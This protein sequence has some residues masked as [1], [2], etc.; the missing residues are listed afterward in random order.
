[1]AITKVSRGL[2]ST[3]VSD[4]SD[5]TAITIDSSENV[6]IGT[7]SPARKVQIQD[8]S[9]SVYLAVTSANNNAA[10]IMFGDT[11]DETMGRVTYDNTNNSMQFWTNDSQKMLIDS[12]GN[13]GIGTSS[14]AGKLQA[15]T[16][17]NRFQSLQGAAADLEIVSDNN[18]SPVALIKGTGNADLLNVFD[19]TTE[20][21]TILDGGN[22]GIGTDSPSSTLDVRG[23]FHVG[24]SASTT[25]VIGRSLAPAGSQG[26]LLTSGLV[27]G[28][29]TTTPTFADNS[30][31]GASI[32]LAGNAADQYGGNVILKAYGA[33]GTATCNLITFENRSGTNTFA[34]RMRIDN[35]GT[36][37]VGATSG[38][39]WLAT[40]GKYVQLGDTYPLA[41]TNNSICSIL[42]RT[43][44]DGTILEFKKDASVVGSISTNA[45]SLPSDRN[46]KKDIEDLNIG[47][48]LVSKLNPVSYNYKIDNDGTP[49]MYGL[50]AQDLEQ[51][52]EEVGVDKNSVQLLQHKPN[53][54]EKESDYGLD[55]LKLTPILIKAIQELSA[56]VEELKTK[57][58]NK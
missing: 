10:G 35:S 32:F 20:V 9:A 30:S 13:L 57:L 3:G 41:V 43:G 21:F 23:V 19:N 26:L 12:S 39:A 37:Y 50:I 49:K 14:P 25:P 18:S 47:L 44:S 8:T 36:V 48:D 1:M 33:A 5:A 7:T 17:A 53:D 16:S 6:G 58:E 45:N 34:E 22:V 54:D 15:Y 46:F 38:D 40:S 27:S 55:Y 52:L 11:D 24:A 28:E 56:E 4:S 42:N 29:S 2:L 51:S 31:S